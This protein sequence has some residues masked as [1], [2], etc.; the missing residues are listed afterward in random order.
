MD[1]IL[2]QQ[3]Q[4]LN[5]NNR[6][7]VKSDIQ[8]ILNKFGI[9]QPINDLTLYQQAFVHKSYISLPSSPVET[10]SKLSTV[11]FQ[12]K[13]YE[14]L[15]YIGDAILNAVAGSYVFFRYPTQP[16]GFLT[17]L[18]TKLVRTNALSL[19]ATELE[20]GQ[21]ILLSR[22]LDMNYGARQ[23]AQILEDVF[24]ALVGA[25]YIDFGPEDLGWNTCQK[26]VIGAFETYIDITKMI[27]KEDNY[28]K[29]L[30]EY[31]QKTYHTEPKYQIISM[32]GPPN[33][34]IYTMGALSTGGEIIGIGVSKR[35]TEA[36]QM[37]SKK[38]LIYYRENVDSDS[39]QD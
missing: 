6:L 37:A 17:T 7:L 19:L 11:P 36:E 10:L 31:Y 39:E 28:K 25:L 34:R 2:K 24:E 14:R 30:L 4:E 21:F 22:N 26:F 13:S 5:P 1:I 15:E 38:A 12:P 32:Q 20:L 16:E 3:P 29:L 27:L 18:R 9:T 35:K 33:N 8:L 23:N